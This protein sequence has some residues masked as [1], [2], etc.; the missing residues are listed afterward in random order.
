MEA[1]D[2]IKDF[3]V[4]HDL[5]NKNSLYNINI[6]LQH[7]GIRI[8]RMGER[9]FVDEFLSQGDDMYL[10]TYKEIPTDSNDNSIDT[11]AT[12]SGYIFVTPLTWDRTNMLVFEELNKSR[13]KDY[14][15]SMG[16]DRIK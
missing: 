7:K 3:F 1:L 11:N 13:D 15:Q 8:T 5:M 14:G 6:P 16:K 9:Y 12:L 10:P 4:R 2:E